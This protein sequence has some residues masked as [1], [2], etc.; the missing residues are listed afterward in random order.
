M[1]KPE[2]TLYLDLIL[3]SIPDG[4]ITCTRDL[5][6]SSMNPAAESL[7]GISSSKCIGKPLDHF[8]PED[9]DMRRVLIDTMAATKSFVSHDYA[10]TNRT[11]IRFRLSLVG[12]SLTDPR[13]SVIGLVLIL[14]DA[15][16]LRLLEEGLRRKD[17]LAIVGTLAAGMAHEIKNPLGGVRGSA[18]LLRERAGDRDQVEL[19]D[20][21]I[22]EVDRIDFLVQELLDLARPRDY[23]FSPANVHQILDEVLRLMEKSLRDRDVRVKREYDPSLPPLRVDP[24]RIRQVFLNLLSNAVE[25][26]PGGGDLTVTTQFFLPPHSDRPI[27]SERGAGV[28]LIEFK[29]TGPG[30]DEGTAERLFTPFYTTKKNGSGLGLAV[31]YKIVQEHRGTIEL[32]NR[33][34]RRGCSAQV[35]LPI[36]QEKVL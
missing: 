8:F 16:T 6:V 33:K 22:K 2:I 15:T 28:V 30:L 14:R 20:I 21:I 19:L 3:A 25:A 27:V 11:G 35:Y 7:V 5:T 10:Y 13:G 29:D 1:E 34:E 17:K 23:S 32:V 36:W 4:I 24:T 18:Q 31:S 12:A 9:P 26:M